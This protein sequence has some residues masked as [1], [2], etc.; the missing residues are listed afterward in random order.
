MD[1]AAVAGLCRL[2]QEDFDLKA[3]GYELKYA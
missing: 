2:A 3:H 1:G